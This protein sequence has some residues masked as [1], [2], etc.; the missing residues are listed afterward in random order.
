MP[1]RSGEVDVVEKTGF[2]RAF[3]KPKQRR[4]F[5]AARP[6]PNDNVNAMMRVRGR[7]MKKVVSITGHQNAIR[8]VGK[9]EHSLVGGVAR[10]RLA[11]QH[12]LMPEL[13][14]QVA[15]VFRHIMIEEE[16]HDAGA[17]ICL[18]T[19]KSISPRWSS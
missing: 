4:E 18:A 2:S 6:A 17:D 14:Q 3:K 19:S 15:Q 1:P 9:A 5:L 11:Q 8:I 12:D 13:F 10:Q 7:E 16:L